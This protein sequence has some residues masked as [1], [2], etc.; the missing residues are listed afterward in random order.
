MSVLHNKNSNVGT[1]EFFIYYLSIYF[2]ISK[3]KTTTVPKKT[4]CIV[5]NIDP[6]ILIS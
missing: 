6:S 2:L 3:T 4:V 5:I 1:L